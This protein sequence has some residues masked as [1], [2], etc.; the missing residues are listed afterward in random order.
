MYELTK[1]AFG[2]YTR[3]HLHNPATGT[4]FSIVPA[5]GANV[6]HLDFQG[7]NV[8]DG[9]TTPEEL[10][11][12]KWGKSVL[13][14]P[15]PNRLDRGRYTWQGQ[16]YQFPI[17]NA[18][19]ENAIH[20]FV[21]DEAFEVDFIFLAKDHAS[22]LCSY[23]YGG[24]R[25]YYPFPFCL[26]VEFMI[27]DDGTFTLE[28]AVENLHDQ[29]IPIGFGWHPYFQLTEG[30]DAHLMQLPTCE[31]VYINERMIP[32]GQRTAF[33]D[34]QRKKKMGDTFL[35]NCF[36]AAKPGSYK[37][38]L[39]HGDTTLQVCANSQDCPFFQVFTPPHRESIA[40]EPMTCNVDAFHNGDG[41]VTVFP[42]QTWKVDFTVGLTV[43]G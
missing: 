27:H 13:L 15:F 17:N 26:E 24:G 3:Y 31:K 42:G 32:T 39:Q 4:G 12:A 16:E 37:M 9:Y 5:R 35:D 21:R 19:T 18:A 11:A 20:G 29:P 38:T 23:T 30:A 1:S 6:L 7:K 43:E 36:A 14:F 33:P 41:L 25:E 28:A 2:K 10:E 22:I 40:L 8:L 34:F